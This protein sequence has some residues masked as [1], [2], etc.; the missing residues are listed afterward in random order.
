ML[1]DILT[2]R[3]EPPRE[4]LDAIKAAVINLT[5][6]IADKLGEPRWTEK[7]AEDYANCGGWNDYYA[8]GYS[9]EHAVRED[10]SYW[11]D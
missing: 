3:P 10:M 8:D 4:Y 5:N 7:E 1:Y 6:P 9:A 2:R 11:N